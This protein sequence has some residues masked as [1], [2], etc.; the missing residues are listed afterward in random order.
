MNNNREDMVKRLLIDDAAED[1]RWMIDR[2]LEDLSMPN[3]VQTGDPGTADETTA[4]TS[5]RPG[6]S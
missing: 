4:K 6:R 2:L 3:S 5:C 1:P